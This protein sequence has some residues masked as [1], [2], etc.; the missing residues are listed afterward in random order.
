MADQI[1]SYPFASR[2]IGPQISDREVMLTQLGLSSIEDLVDAL[3]VEIRLDAPLNLPTAMTEAEAEN[4]LRAYSEMNNPCR[5]MIGLGYYGTLTPTV[6]RRNV[7]EN[8]AWYTAYTPYQAEISQ[9]R[10]EA[11]LNFQTLVSDMTGFP[12]AGASLLDEA[13]AVAEAMAMTKRMTKKGEIILL[14]EDIFPQSEAVVRARA[15]ATG[16]QVVKASGDL[17]AALQEHEAFAVVVQVPGASGHIRPVTELKA[18]ADKAHE[19]GAMVI[20]A[21]DLLSLALVVPPAEW[22][23]DLAVGSTQRFGVPLFYGGPH[24]GYIAVAAGTERNMP[25]RLVGISVDA[26][27]TPAIRL[28][29]TTREQHIRRERATSNICTSQVLLAV[30]ASMYAVYHGPVGIKS[31]ATQIHETT[32]TLAQVLTKAGFELVSDTF[33]DTIVVK[34]A[35]AAEKIVEKA[36]DGGVH[37]RLVDADHVGIS[38]GED[39]TETDL[40]I[41][42]D[43]FGAQWQEDGQFGSLGDHCRESEFLTHPVFNAHHS[44][45]AMLR[46]LRKLSDRDF[47]LDRG[48][49]PL[50]SCT[51]KLNPTSAMEPISYPGFADLHPFCPAED[52]EGYQA[53]ITE[54]CDWLVEI[55]GYDAV[56]IQPNAGSAGEFAG[57]MAIRSYHRARGDEQRTKMLIPSSAHGTNAAS[58][59][60]AGMQVVVVKAAGDGTIDLD[61]LKAKIEKHGDTI[62]GMMITYPSTHGVYEDTVVTVCEM[63]HAA[64]GQMYVDGANM[65]AL[66][67]L[68]KPGKFGADVSH[69]N[70]H[71]T[72]AIPHGGGGPGIG[73]VALRSHLAP[74]LPNHPLAEHAGPG[75]SYGPVAAAP[76]GS[77]G[78][79]PITWAYIA[80]MGAEGLRDATL[81]AVLNANYIAKKLGDA[82]PILYTGRGGFVAHEC[83]LDLSGIKKDM[84]I[85]NNDVAKRLV[86]YGFHAPTMSFPVPDTLMVEPTE[87]ESL[88]EIDRFIDAM[89]KIR[90]EIDKVASGEWD[91]ADNPLV[92]APHTQQRVMAEEW[93]HPYTRAEAGFPGGLHTGQIAATG[94]VKYWPSVARVDEVYGDR[95][96]ICTCPPMDSYED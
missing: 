22:G 50:G 27:G 16:I 74:Y 26:D 29:L 23:A 6:V 51:M 45:T 82:F 32:R 28:A 53:M 94:T 79:S 91:L 54:L 40:F 88:Y 47:A 35:G 33:F 12:T 69:L 81:T 78:V 25:G 72:F 67:G 37:L 17:V 39:I 59:T 44:E 4:R 7:L 43:A 68:A 8:P 9:G 65:N 49:I 86:D 89:L 1:S 19:N 70:L 92:N 55:T 36:R 38:V 46:Y 76:F 66:V 10:L 34:T 15:A 21:A 20:A 42:A 90:A 87:S 18:I 64:G 3:P 56:S 24:A 80:M 13:T 48:M 95:N 71:K 60:M 5:A 31:I 96:F 41:V 62:A 11:L 83:I 93:T 52:A 2:H 57:L 75:T 73:P 77:A 84:H 58:A 85:T 30:T 63:V 61:D 14:D